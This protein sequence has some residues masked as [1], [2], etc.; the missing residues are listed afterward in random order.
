MMLEIQHQHSVLHFSNKINKKD[1]NDENIADGE[2]YVLSAR[3][4]ELSKISYSRTNPLGDF[5]EH[6]GFLK[7]EVKLLENAHFLGII[8]G[9]FYSD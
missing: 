7:E 5:L 6:S 3:K 8:A 2:F 1:N 9:L 4:T